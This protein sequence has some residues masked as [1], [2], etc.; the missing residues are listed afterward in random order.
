MVV[1]TGFVGNS[2]VT[3]VVENAA[4]VHLIN[5]ETAKRLIL[6]E[7]V[8]LKIKVS[9]FKGP[10]E[11]AKILI[12]SGQ[13]IPEECID[14]AIKNSPVLTN[15]LAAKASLTLDQMMKFVEI[16]L[17]SEESCSQLI[18][19]AKS[20]QDAYLLSRIANYLYQSKSTSSSLGTLRVILLDNPHLPVDIKVYI[21]GDKYVYTKYHAGNYYSK[22]NR[23]CGGHTDLNTSNPHLKFFSAD[24]IVN[25]LVHDWYGVHEGFFSH[26]RDDF[27][28]SSPT[29]NTVESL[30]VIEDEL[31]ARLEDLQKTGKDRLS[32]AI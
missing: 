8:P 23:S 24:P 16:Y 29:R 4:L 26:D 9:L 27:G 10:I 6:D 19:I 22:H 1:E 5:P 2:G 28:C 25:K 14:Y 20:T 3:A 32:K 13:S 31:D 30:K 18:T 17:N 21:S 15:L 7:T 11:F 12:A